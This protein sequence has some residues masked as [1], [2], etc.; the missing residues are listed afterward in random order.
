MPRKLGE[1]LSGSGLS[2]CSEG[3]AVAHPV[4]RRVLEPGS[5]TDETRGVH[6]GASVAGMRQSLTGL[7]AARAAG[8]SEWLFDVGVELLDAQ[9]VALASDCV[10]GNGTIRVWARSGAAS[11]NVYSSPFASFAT[12]PTR[13]RR[14]ATASRRCTEGTAH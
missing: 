8:T 9:R 7:P 4:Q 6:A 2:G 1:I 13:A 3:V 12:P 10:D 14:I 11:G 5:S